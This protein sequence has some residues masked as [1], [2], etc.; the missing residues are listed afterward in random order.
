MKRL[1][2][3][4]WICLRAVEWGLCFT[5]GTLHG[6]A[7]SSAQFVK[8]LLFELSKCRGRSGGTHVC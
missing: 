8:T 2:K 4:Q 7:V 6:L 5:D 3:T 1:T